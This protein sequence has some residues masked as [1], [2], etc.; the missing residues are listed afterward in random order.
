MALMSLAYSCGIVTLCHLVARRPAAPL[1]GRDLPACTS[2][3]PYVLLSL[4]RRQA[5]RGAAP[6]AVLCA[7]PGPGWLRHL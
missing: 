3:L 7:G 2:S 5:Y 1:T 6:I 4:S